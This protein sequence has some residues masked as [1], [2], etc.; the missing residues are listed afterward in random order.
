MSGELLPLTRREKSFELLVY[1][2]LHGGA[3]RKRLTRM[4]WS[5]DMPGDF[6]STLRHLRD[7]L[8]Q[9]TGLKDKLFIGYDNDRYSIDPELISVDLWDFR[10]DLAELRTAPK[11]QTRISI[12]ERVVAL[13][14]GP[15]LDGTEFDWRDQEAY[16]ITSAMVDAF[17]Q[18]AELLKEREPE[19]AIELLER[20]IT[21]LPD[22]ESTYRDLITVQWNTRRRADARRTAHIL[23]QRI[24]M[25]GDFEVE[26][27]EILTQ[28]L[29][30]ASPPPRT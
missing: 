20:A 22:R 30:S 23:M 6:H 4:L 10:R 21:L 7:P 9:T 12:L 26:T 28:V 13:L 16:P 8:K 2:A 24:S 18:L 11:D 3:T 5:E 14:R 27:R 1:L 19:R 17:T 29:G 15:A 25:I